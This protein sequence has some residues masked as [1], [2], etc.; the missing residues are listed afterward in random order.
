MAPSFSGPLKKSGSGGIHPSSSS[1]MPF[2]PLHIDGPSNSAVGRL[3]CRT[4]C[5]CS[6]DFL[7]IFVSI[8]FDSSFFFSSSPIA[9]PPIV[10]EYIIN[11]G[12]WFLRSSPPAPRVHVPE[13]PDINILVRRFAAAA[14]AAASLEFKTFG[15]VHSAI[16]K[17]PQGFEWCSKRAPVAAIRK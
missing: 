8:Y 5:D 6:C 12:Y 17:K 2:S 10:K 14:A 3:I 15:L 1:S 13:E 11:I 9:Q 4:P 16:K 7:A